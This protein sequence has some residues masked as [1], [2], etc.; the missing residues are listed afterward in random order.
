MATVKTD[1]AT[2]Q[3]SNSVRDRGD[4]N[5]VSGD[6][7][8]AEAV[9]TT[10]AGLAAGDIIDIVQLPIGA[11]VL[12]E[13]S[14]VAN[15]A[16]GGTGAAIAKIG[17]AEDDDRYSATSIDLTSAGARAVTAVNTTAV[18][19]RTPVTKTTNTIKATVALTSGNVTA[20]KLI[21]FSIAYILP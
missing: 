18:L 17:D 9:Y 2:S 3:S 4:S 13:R 15:E 6:I 16:S 8:I 10:T 12:P 14:W 11:I 21:R 19:V 1:V 5:K 20:G 7:R